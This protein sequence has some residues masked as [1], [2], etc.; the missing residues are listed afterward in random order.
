VSFTSNLTVAE[1]HAIRSVGFTPVG[2]VL[3]SCVYAIGYT[4]TWNCGYWGYGGLGGFGG[5]GRGGPGWTAS[6]GWQPGGLSGPGMGGGIGRGIGGGIG[7]GYGGY[8]GVTVVEATGLRDSLYEA[9]TRAMERMRQ[10]AERLGGD[11]VV[12]VR[13]S[14]G[15][16]D[17]AGTLEFRAIGT[18]VRADGPVRPRTPFLSDLTGQEFG[19]LL[20]A[21]WVPAALVLGI[22][23]MVRHDDWATR[24]QTSAWTNQE[25]GGYTDLVTQARAKARDRLRHDCARHG[26]ETV[27]VRD[28]TLHIRERSC[29][30]G[31]SE[32]H[33]HIAETL[34][35]GTAIVPFRHAGGNAPTPPLPVLRLNSGRT[36]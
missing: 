7:G 19:L 31:N 6:P 29:N 20:S 30:A 3:G 24:R 11:G 8:G 26:A 9:R 14:V 32:S 18:A 2:Q 13:L 16:F 1:H 23:V 34:V 17:N 27:V 28:L 35:V 10:E 12:A 33:D 15:P 22:A 4:G 25:V 36:S 5:A 21:G